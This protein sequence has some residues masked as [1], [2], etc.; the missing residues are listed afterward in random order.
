MIVS[1][2]E[3]LLEA[4]GDG[5]FAKVFRVKDHAMLSEK[6]VELLEDE[7]ARTTLAGEAQS[8]AEENFSIDAH[9]KALDSLY[10]KLLEGES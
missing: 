2:I 4:S 10:G 9:L 8:F 6:M 3:P 5:R 7:R 1:D